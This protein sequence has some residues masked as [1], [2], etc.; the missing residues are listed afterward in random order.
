VLTL[1]VSAGVGLSA[2]S[3]TRGEMVSTIVYPPQRITLR[4]DHAAHRQLRCERCHEGASRS[5]EASD[6][7]LP[8]EA[9]CVECHEETDREQASA[10]RCGYCHVGTDGV[11]VPPTEIPPPRLTFSHRTHARR[12]VRCL[13]CHAEIQS[14]AQATRADLP[15]MRSCWRCHGEDGAGRHVDGASS[16][17]GSCHET[18][19][20]G[21][22]RVAFPEGQMLPPRWLHDMDHDRDFLVRH[23]WVGAD[24]GE[25]C[26]QCHSESECNECHDGRVRPS[27]IHPGDFLTTHGPMAR[28]DEHRCASC[29]TTARFCTECHARLGLAPISAPA[30]VSGRRFHPPAE[31]WIRGPRSHGPEA[32]R[33]MNQCASCHAERDCVQCHGAMGI[34][35]GL[36]PH[37]PGFRGQCG[38]ALRRNPRACGTC[39]GDVD[40]LHARCP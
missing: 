31:V 18:R 19:L 17:C 26:A 27:S 5:E 34:G 12:G 35:A 2:R 30:A 15:S 25:R 29:H 23:R 20:D 3:Q 16:D 40:A 21:R 37:P 32:R 22:M 39:H 8:A 10:E 24:Q 1:V 38:E 9:A 36:S 14:R 33:S 13:D 7:L 4:M 6:L 11:H 28:R